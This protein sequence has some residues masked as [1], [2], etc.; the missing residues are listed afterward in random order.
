VRHR[1]PLTL[2]LIPLLGI[3]LLACSS[4]D[5]DAGAT[6]PSAPVDSVVSDLELTPISDPDDLPGDVTKPS[7]DIPAEIPTE[8]VITELRPGEGPEAAAGDTVVVDYVGVRSEDGVEFDSSYERGPLLVTLGAGQVI[9]GW[10]QG[11]IG[12]QTGQQLQLDIPNELAY[13]DQDTGDVIRPGDAL[14]FVVDVR[15]VIPKPLPAD[16]PLDV[17]IEPSV[18]AT[19]VTTTDVVEGDGDTVEAGDTVL[20]QVLIA[21]GDN[22][23]VIYNSWELGTTQKF[24]LEDGA[25]FPGLVEGI[26]G[27]RVGGTR[28]VVMPPESF[29][30]PEGNPQ[31]GLPADTDVIMVVRAVGMV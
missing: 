24:V 2:A 3:T 6:D 29:L 23:A 13:G 28:V 11:L 7:V 17:Q 19:E 16:A 30:G 20:A 5:G 15:T 21:R 26:P 1:R 9:P 31:S 18:G 27:M 4:D 8:L 14:T 25:T 22:E 12:T 10:D